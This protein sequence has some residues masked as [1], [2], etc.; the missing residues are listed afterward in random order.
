MDERV[1]R[2]LARWPGV[3]AVYGW[4]RLDAR[5][6]WRLRT[7]AEGGFE[8]I[9]NAALRAFIA[10]NYASD[11]RGRWFFQNGPQRVYAGLDRTPLVYRLS[12]E[13]LHDH[14]GRS[15]GALSRAWQDDAG[16]LVL[17][18]ARGVGVLDDRDLE[19]ASRTLL[20]V[21]PGG[22]MWVKSAPGVRIPL[23]SLERSTLGR[24]F[25]F[26]PEPAGP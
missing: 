20:G 22:A 15:A 24:R 1:E 25:G 17:L 12:P 21:D 3:P 19:A 8:T 7:R 14:C 16:G 9:G 23:G 18:A 4:L 5:G 10:R 11:E 6:N 26:D 13:G 2:A